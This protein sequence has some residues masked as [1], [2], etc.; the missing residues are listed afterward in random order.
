MLEPFVLYQPVLE[1]SQIDC[2]AREADSTFLPDKYMIKK[3]D[4]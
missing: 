3:N 1:M 4:V 2:D